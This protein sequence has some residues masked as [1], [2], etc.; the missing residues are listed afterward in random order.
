MSNQAL[1]ILLVEDDEIDAEA[2]VRSFRRQQISNPVTI[3]H[4]GIEALNTLRGEEGYTRLPRPYLILLDINMPR[5]NGLEFLE[6]LRRDADLKQSVVFILTTSNRDE[7]KM[8][9]YNSQIAGY[10][11]KSRAGKDFV[12]II[13]LLGSYERLV[14]FPQES[15]QLAQKKNFLH[16]SAKI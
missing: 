13:T 4:D 12:D 14:Q 16:G 15:E 11:L 3:V 1:Q 10:L 5:M 6:I 2:I 9:A 7:D 8:A